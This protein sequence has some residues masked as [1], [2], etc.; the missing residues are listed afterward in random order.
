MNQKE[1]V[2][3][4][5]GRDRWSEGVDHHPESIKLMRFLQA[6]DWD[7]YGGHFDWKT[8]G[9]GDNGE[10]LMFQM[11]AYFEAQDLLQPSHLNEGDRK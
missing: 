5:V 9:D 11:D 3:K 2:A 4:E 1:A 6:V 10:T 8:G 7:A